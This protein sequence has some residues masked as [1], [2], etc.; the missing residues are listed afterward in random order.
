M[1]NFTGNYTDKYQLTMAQIYFLKGVKEPALFDYFFENF[2]L[3]EATQF[4][5]V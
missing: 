2:L 1:F 4:L 3:M 5:L